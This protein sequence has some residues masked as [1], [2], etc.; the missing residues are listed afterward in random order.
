MRAGHHIVAAAANE[1]NLSTICDLNQ[2]CGKV[3]DDANY[4]NGASDAQSRRAGKCNYKKLRQRVAK[5]RDKN[6]A[7]HTSIWALSSKALGT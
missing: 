2:A 7:R 1:P 5:S 3:E 4:G 6:S